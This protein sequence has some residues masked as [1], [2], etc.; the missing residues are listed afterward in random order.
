LARF[1]YGDLDSTIGDLDVIYLLRIQSER[2]GEVL[3]PSLD[4]YQLAL[5]P[6]PGAGGRAQPDALIMASGTDDPRGRDLTGGR[7]HAASL[8]TRQVRNGV[9]VRMAVLFHLLGSGVM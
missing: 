3:L 4:E 7:G 5:R 9:V 8:V 1:R 6:H 2:L